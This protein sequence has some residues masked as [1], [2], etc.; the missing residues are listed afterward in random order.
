MQAEIVR[1]ADMAFVRCD[2]EVDY[3]PA[4][5]EFLQQYYLW[6]AEDLGASCLRY[7]VMDYPWD[8]AYWLIGAEKG[9]NPGRITSAVCGPVSRCMPAGIT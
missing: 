6:T 5:H 7:V 2:E 3:V 4:V 9:F 8:R 1:D